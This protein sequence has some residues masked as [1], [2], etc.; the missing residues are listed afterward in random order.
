MGKETFHPGAG[1][2]KNFHRKDFRELTIWKLAGDNLEHVFWEETK[3]PA[4]T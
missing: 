2:E 4:E 3:K 1:D